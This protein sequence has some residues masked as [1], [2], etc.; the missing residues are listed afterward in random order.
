MRHV[1]NLLRL[2][3]LLPLMAVLSAAASAQC[4][5]AWDQRFGVAGI[6]G[7]VYCAATYDDGGGPALYVGGAFAVA[8]TAAGANVAKRS[9]NTWTSPGGG[10]PSTSLPQG[11]DIAPV[12]SLTVFDDGTGPR[13][14]AARLQ[15]YR[16]TGSSWV[17]LTSATTGIGPAGVNDLEVHDDGT[18]SA[19]YAT[20]D[21]LRPG[22]AFTG[23]ARWNGT[24]WVQVGADFLGFA[25][26][27]PQ[28]L[29]L[30]KHT[31]ALG[32]TVLYAGG[33]F[34]AVG[35]ASFSSIAGWN[36]SAWVNPGGGVVN[37]VSFHATSQTGM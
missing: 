22:G 4:Q 3:P 18:G 37:P 10:L 28:A 15:V 29:C 17:M 34:A 6:E 23:V 5:F 26:N 8:E 27:A 14:Y 21:F 36:G 12:R 32:A 7:K 35:A 9:G 24:N 1:A 31:S 11:Q 25:S 2:A 19:L 33:S 20:G 13:L 16:L 30:E